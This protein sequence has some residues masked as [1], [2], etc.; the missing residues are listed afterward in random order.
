MKPPTHVTLQPRDACVA[1]LIGRVALRACV[2]QR[3]TAAGYG[4]EL[5]VVDN[6]VECESGWNPGAVGRAGEASLFQIHPVN[7]GR[8]GGRNPWDPVANTDVALQMRREQ[9]WWPWSCY[10]RIYGG[11]TR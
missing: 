4:W 8:F 11:Q 1:P 2:H 10:R 6:V 3:W 7:F 5:D 9:G